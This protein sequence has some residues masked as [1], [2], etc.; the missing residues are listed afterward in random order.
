M[1]S[2]KSFDTL[3]NAKLMSSDGT[4]SAELNAYESSAKAVLMED[5]KTSLNIGESDTPEPSEAQDPCDEMI[6]LTINKI[7]KDFNN[8]SGLRTDNITITLSRSWTDL[9]NENHTETVPG[10]ENYI[11]NGS[12]DLSTWQEVITGLPSYKTDE[13]GNIY[14]YTYSVTEAK[15]DGYT[16][17]IK[18]SKDGFT[19]SITNR[20]I[21]GL[22]D[23][24]GDGRYAIYMM[25]IL[26]F[27]I[28]LATGDRKRK[29]KHKA[30]QL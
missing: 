23:T 11:I 4:A 6:S 28:Y 30:E 9:Q 8:L 5:T 27:A 2:V 14:Y 3:Q 17:T 20:H 29:R 22:P 15:V 19:F 21:P 25:A 7:W 16:T 1:H 18:P 10:Y 24:G 13:N 26:L 12:S